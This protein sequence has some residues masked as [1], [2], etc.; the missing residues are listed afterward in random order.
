MPGPVLADLSGLTF[1]D[2]DG[3]RVLD[4][5]TQT[6][7][8]GRQVAVRFCLRPIRH[9]LDLWLVL[10]LPAV[11]ARR[12]LR[13][14]MTALSDRARRARLYAGNTR[15]DASGTLARLADTYIRLANTVERAD[16]ILEQGRHAVAASRATRECAARSRQAAQP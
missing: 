16:L 6:L 4:A 2:V 7:P 5:V 12:C 14:G 13:A 1:I 8:D 11:Q 10:G 9:V 3:V 15:L